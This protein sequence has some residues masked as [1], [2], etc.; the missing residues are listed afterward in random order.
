M[1]HESDLERCEDNF[2]NAVSVAGWVVNG[3]VVMGIME[4][5]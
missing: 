3:L 5:P 2:E 1:K 4:S